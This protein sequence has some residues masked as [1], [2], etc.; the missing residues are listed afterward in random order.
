M[1]LPSLATKVMACSS[2]LANLSRSYISVI[3]GKG[4]SKEAFDALKDHFEPKRPATHRG[5][6]AEF[7]SM[8][9][10]PHQTAARF[11]ADIEELHKRVNELKPGSLD[12]SAK[13]T[14]LLNGLSELAIEKWKCR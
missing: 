9:M 6:M 5:L 4:T 3:R 14:A 2:L 1:A 11:Y 10:G 12:D 7:W 13:V 8:R